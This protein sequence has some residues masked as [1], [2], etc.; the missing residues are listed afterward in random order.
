MYS[1]YPYLSAGYSTGSEGPGFKSLNLSLSLNIGS[2]HIA[3]YE[4]KHA[5][6][7]K[8]WLRV[9]V[10]LRGFVGHA[11]AYTHHT[12]MLT[13][14]TVQVPGAAATVEEQEGRV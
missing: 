6:M 11:S 4:S 14:S 9:S 2:P 3:W 1:N 7:P 10:L 13:S 12:P 8:S 5:Q